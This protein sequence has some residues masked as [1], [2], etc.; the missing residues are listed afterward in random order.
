MNASRR[1]LLKLTAAAAVLPSLPRLARA[2][3]YPTRPVRI[4]VGFPA[5]GGVDLAARLIG[6]WLSERLGQP[7]I[8]EN[9]PGA[10]TNT[11]TADVV[12]GVSDGYTLLMACLPNASNATLYPDLKFNFLRDIAPVAGLLR[13]PFVVETH[14]SLPVTTIP[15]LISFASANPGKI[16]MASAGGVGNGTHLAGALFQTMTGVKFVHVPYRAAGLALTDLLA[17]RVQLMF[18]SMSSSIGYVRAGKLRPLAVTST[19]SSPL[20]PGTPTLTESVPGYA[21]SFWYGVGVRYGTPAEIIERLNK[22]I[23]A[24][25]TDGKFK[26]QL[27]EF[28]GTPLPGS[29]ADFGKLIADETDKWREVIRAANIVLP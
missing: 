1:R 10:A 8:V 26:M 19:T 17:G 4:I 14:P 9:R 21:F 6:H 20:L 28:G 25:L 27:G 22:E 15:E 2:D 16:N 5:G 11:A 12:N 23:N 24:A 3:A 29:P 18:A 7:F 13:E